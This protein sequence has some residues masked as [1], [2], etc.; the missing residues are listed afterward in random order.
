MK[1]H[2]NL[3]I[4]FAI[5]I[6][7][8]A[9]F[10]CSS[11]DNEIKDSF[12]GIEKVKF[13]SENSNSFFPQD[14]DYYTYTEDGLLLNLTGGRFLSGSYEY[15]E[16]RKLI[17]KTREITG[18]SFTYEYDMQGRIVRQ[19]VVGSND[20]IALKFENDKVISE[21]YYETSGNDNV[22]EKKELS[23][24]SKG[25]IVKVKSLE[26]VSTRFQPNEVR[27]ELI[28]FFDEIIYEYDSNGNIIKVITDGIAENLTYDNAINPFYITFKKHYEINYYIDNYFGLRVY[29]STGLSPNNLKT[30]GIRTI[31]YVY[32]SDN[33][34]ISW[35]TELSVQGGGIA[36][37]FI[38]YKE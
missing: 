26:K 24:N 33:Y 23:L 22:Y 9:F 36:E 15:D 34:P 3:T 19:K 12:S 6:L 32:D 28:P 13:I 25:L 8:L 21:R 27:E 31:N 20:Y 37:Q 11:D 14:V 16:N 4:L 1:R 30:E 18:E 29:H 17:S 10:S 2:F 35:S 7:V 5:L 38:K